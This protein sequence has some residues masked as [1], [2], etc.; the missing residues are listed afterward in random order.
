[1]VLADSDRISRARPYSGSHFGILLI[2][3]TGLSPSS[4]DFPKS[5]VYNQY[6]LLVVVLLPHVAMVW[7]L[8]ISLAATLEI[9]F[10]FFSF[11]YLD[12][13]VPWVCL[14]LPYLFR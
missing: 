12:V 5:F 4:V 2:L 14:L 1:M 8:S 9:D 10:S 6:F 13:S 11:R 3:T 7:A